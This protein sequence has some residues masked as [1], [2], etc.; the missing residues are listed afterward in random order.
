MEAPRR[1][2]VLWL[3]LAATAFAVW[4]GYLAW[5]VVLHDRPMIHFGPFRIE[6]T[7]EVVLSRSQLLASQLVVS[8]ELDQ[9]NGSIEH[10]EVLWHEPGVDPS[11]IGETLKIVNLSASQDPS[12]RSPA[13]PGRYLLPLSREGDVY[14][15]VPIPSTPGY[16]SFTPGHPGPP[17]IYPDD[18]DARKQLEEIVRQRR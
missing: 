7:P 6:K 17:R 13:L 14:Q 3:V 16:P 15:I 9:L 18:Q 4:I 10:S 12:G 8:A 1:R 5:L 11:K 2:Q